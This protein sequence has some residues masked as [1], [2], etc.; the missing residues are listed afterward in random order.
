MQQDPGG[1]Q[2][3]GGIQIAGGGKSGIWGLPMAWFAALLTWMES[4]FSKVF[5]IDIP[6]RYAKCSLNCM[7]NRLS[8]FSLVRVCQRRLSR[9]ALIWA[10]PHWQCWIETIFRVRSV[11]TRLP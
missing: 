3:T 8:V 10:Y 2:G 5:T 9:P 1:C 7:P 4:G 11:F 6:D